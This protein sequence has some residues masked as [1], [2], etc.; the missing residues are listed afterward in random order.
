MNY[1]KICGLKE[2]KNIQTCIDYGADAIGFIYN[3]PKSPRNLNQRNINQFHKSVY[4]QILTVGVTKAKKLRDINRMNAKID[5]DLLQ[6]H[7]SLSFDS[8]SKLSSSLKKKMIIARKMNF[9]NLKKL[10]NDIR[11]HSDDFYGFLIDNSE[12]HG[13]TLKINLVK[14]FLDGLND[15]RIIL[16]GGISIG[17]IEQVVMNLNP[18]GI[19]VSSSLESK[20]GLKNDKK[21]EDF[22]KKINNINDKRGLNS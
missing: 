12:G 16:A 6:I 13:D 4:N 19:D 22:L 2:I 20:K 21:I 18:Y 10:Q 3:V 1:V 11:K 7:C 17:N 9:S 5:T 15:E 14:H 8:L